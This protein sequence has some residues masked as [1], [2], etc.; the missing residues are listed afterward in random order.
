MPRPAPRRRVICGSS[1]LIPVIC[2]V[3][4]KINGR[5]LTAALNDFAVMN[6]S[7]PNAGSSAMEMLSAETL[8]ENSEKLRSPTLTCRRERR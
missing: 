1:S 5:M 3:L 8:P 7:L 4:E 6:A 2:K